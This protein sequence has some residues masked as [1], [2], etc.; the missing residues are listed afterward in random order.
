MTKPPTDD[1]LNA[2]QA[3]ADAATKEKIRI[4]FDGPPGPECG[5]FIE[6]ENM[7]GASISIGEWIEDSNGNG[8]DDGH[9]WFLEFPDPRNVSLL[10]QIPDL[11]AEVKRLRKAGRAAMLL[12]EKHYGLANPESAMLRAALAGKNPG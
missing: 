1:E 7:L 6:V 2:I 5:R 8:V 10:Y 4:R 3:R 12:F 11:L 9:D